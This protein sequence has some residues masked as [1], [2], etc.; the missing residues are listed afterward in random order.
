LSVK[1]GHLL[2]LFYKFYIPIYAFLP[3]ML[4]LKDVSAVAVRSRSSQ[5]ASH[6]FLDCLVSFVVKTSQDVRT[7]PSRLVF[8]YTPVSKR[9]TQQEQI[10]QYPKISIISKAARCPTPSSNTISLTYPKSFV[11]PSYI[12]KPK[13]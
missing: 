13:D 4:S 5:P 1:S 3:A 9:E 8:L 2:L 7:V 10:F 6:G 11:L 12:K